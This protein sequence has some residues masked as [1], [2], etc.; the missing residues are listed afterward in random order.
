[1]ATEADGYVYSDHHEHRAG[2]DGNGGIKWE[3]LDKGTRAW[4]P[5]NYSQ[6]PQR[7]RERARR[8]FARQP[9]AAD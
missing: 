1:M 4:R 3:A 9:A 6:I 5:V 2:S 7:L 8:E